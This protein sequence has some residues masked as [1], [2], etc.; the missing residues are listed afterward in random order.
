MPQLHITYFV[1][2]VDPTGELRQQVYDRARVEFDYSRQLTNRLIEDYEARI[3]PL[4]LEAQVPNYHAE[5]EEAEFYSDNVS[6]D[7]YVDITIEEGRLRPEH[8]IAWQEE[9]F[10]EWAQQA[11]NAEVNPANN[12]ETD[13]N[14]NN[15]TISVWSTKA[16]P[17]NGGKRRRHTKKRS[18][19]RKRRPCLKQVSR[20][21]R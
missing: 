14:S 11:I 13:V 4:Y 1:V 3:V 12:N 18:T 7:R 9:Q 5:L 21:R 19:R 17:L 2:G 6:D 20:R 16:R 15:N 8:R 10:A